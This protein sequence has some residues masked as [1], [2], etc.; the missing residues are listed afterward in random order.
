[1]KTR[2]EN[3]NP[4]TPY[5]AEI[6]RSRG[7]NQ[8]ILGQIPADDLPHKTYARLIGFWGLPKS[9]EQKILHPDHLDGVVLPLAKAALYGLPEESD[10]N[11]KQLLQ[12]MGVIIAFCRTLSGPRPTK[13][14]MEK[15]AQQMKGLKKNLAALDKSIRDI[16]YID[17]KFCTKESGGGQL[18]KELP[19]S[20]YIKD[21]LIN[22][23]K[24]CKKAFGMPDKVPTSVRDFF[25]TATW[26]NGAC[27]RIDLTQSKFFSEYKANGRMSENRNNALLALASSYEHCFGINPTASAA[28]SKAS[29]HYFAEILM[30]KT[31]NDMQKSEFD[32]LIRQII[33]D[34]DT[35]K[36]QV[37]VL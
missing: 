32:A 19:I 30:K 23:Y 9:K 24:E 12:E 11:T 15:T 35:T 3:K 29:Y 22:E 21:R 2:V 34:Y 13:K 31:S 36:V 27:K 4:A 14:E 37:E 7:K 1:M 25:E 18:T 17:E 33:S 20:G 8:A 5:V 28:K 6:I 16:F 10:D 26:I